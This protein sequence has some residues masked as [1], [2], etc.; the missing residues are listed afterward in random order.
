MRRRRRGVWASD[1]GGVVDE[2]DRMPW[3]GREISVDAGAGSGF[4]GRFERGPRAI[5]NNGYGWGRNR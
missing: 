2:V 3:C 4:I 1:R 5:E